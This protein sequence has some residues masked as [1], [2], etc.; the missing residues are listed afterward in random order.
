MKKWIV[1]GFVAPALVVGLLIPIV[2]LGAFASWTSTPSDAAASTDALTEIPPVALAAYKAAA[3][4]CPGLSWTVLAAIGKVE[5][6]HGTANGHHLDDAGQAQPAGLHSNIS[7]GPLG[8]AWGPMQF[9]AG[10]W[11]HYGP[12]V[13]PGAD[14]ADMQT[15]PVQNI[16]TA[17]KAAALLLCS[18]AGGRITDEAMLHRAIDA[19]S[20]ST[21]G[22]YDDVASL[23]HVYGIPAPGGRNAGTPTEGT[24][25]RLVLAATRFVGVPYFATGDPGHVNVG[26]PPDAWL[27]GFLAGNPAYFGLECSG[28][29]NVAMLVAFGVNQNRCSADYAHD[30]HNFPHVPMDQLEPGDLVTRG[31]CGQTG[32]IAIVA[33]YD[34]ITHLATTIDA[35]RHGTVVG[36][37]R[38]QDVRS[39]SFTDAVRYAG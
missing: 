6:G 10:T 29:V 34:P 19:Y 35:A 1:A 7:N 23:A 4:L 5:T 24:G 38:A 20:G 36:F 21:D 12:L 32:H 17:T 30:P 14:N 11:A 25:M 31:P 16:N 15:G 26:H 33:W 37:R 13:A 3:P 27:A 22:Y 28:L 8:Y 39:W 9:L 2:L 18:A